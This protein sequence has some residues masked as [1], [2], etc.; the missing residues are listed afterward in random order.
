[1]ASDNGLA[2][3]I[4][5][6]ARL[7]QNELVDGVHVVAAVNRGAKADRTLAQTYQGDMVTLSFQLPGLKGMSVA[8]RL[9][10]AEASRLRPS[11]ATEVAKDIARS[12]ARDVS[13]TTVRRKTAVACEPV[14]SVLTE[15][16]K[17]LEPGRCIT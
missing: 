3:A 4:R 5:G 1:M 8:M 12:S 10:N 2:R 15:V 17:Q 13:K 14:V 11:M 7:W 6:D 9:P 16:A